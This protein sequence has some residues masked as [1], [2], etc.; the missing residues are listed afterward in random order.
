MKIDPDDS[1]FPQM[2]DALGD[3]GCTSYNCT[4]GL[5]K[6]EYALIKIMAGFAADP[7][8]SDNTPESLANAADRWVN[9]LFAR[10]NHDT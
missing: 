9:A 10:L 2:R 6:R 7:S 3:T 8:S 5:T 1:A 4:P